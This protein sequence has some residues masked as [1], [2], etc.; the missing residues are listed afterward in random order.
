MIGFSQVAFVLKMALTF[1]MKDITFVGSMVAFFVC[2]LH[3]HSHHHTPHSLPHST[4]SQSGINT[5]PPKHD[6]F[7]T[8]LALNLKE[9]VRTPH[10]FLGTPLRRIWNKR[11]VVIT[12]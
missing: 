12:F 6:I 3:L 7:Y 8:K 5:L 4:A 11:K 10:Y 2:P 1:F 9:T